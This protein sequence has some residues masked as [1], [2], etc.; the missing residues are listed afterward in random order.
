MTFAGIQK[1]TLLDYPGKTACT[2]FTNGCNLRCPFCY[3]ARL[4]LPEYQSTSS[5][6]AE[7][8]IRAFLKKRAGLLDGICITGGEPLLHEENLRDFIPYIR[9]LGYM[10]K[11]DTNGTCPKILEQFLQL[12]W[13]DYVA[14]DV[15]N[16][17]TYYAETIGI[18]DFNVTPIKE[19]IDI[20]R[21]SGVDYEFRTTVVREFHTV[22][23]IRELAQSIAGAKRYFLQKFLDS[24]ELI[25]SGLSAV[26]AEEMQ[27][28]QDVASQF[29]PTEIRG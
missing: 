3:N 8:E 13:I 26:S 16:T 20:I 27:A 21:N 11:L 18:A 15:K 22:E 5:L 9:E 24:G 23:R 4:V 7:E 17:F 1:L 14:M 19:S 2:V 12:G 29:C 28:M 6:L 10:V 25:S